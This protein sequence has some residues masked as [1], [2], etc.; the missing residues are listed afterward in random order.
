MK[1]IVD[2]QLPFSLAIFIRNKGHDVIHTDDLPDKERTSDTEIRSIARRDSRIV[3]SKDSDF[4]ESHLLYQ[5][6]TQLLWVA[7]GNIRNRD[8]FFLFEQNWSEIEQRFQHF[9]L[10][11]LNNTN[12]VAY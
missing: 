4:V 1:F 6:P 2:A 9:N 3:V 12:L 8:L 5:N 11:E 10:L 7:T